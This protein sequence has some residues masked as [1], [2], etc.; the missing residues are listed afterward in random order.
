MEELEYEAQDYCMTVHLF[1]AVSS[2]A[3]ANFVL[4]RTADD[5]KDSYGTEV[6]YTL[7][8]NF[9]VDDVL[10]PATTGDKTIKLAKDVKA[11]CGNEGFNLTKFVGNTDHI[12]VN[13]LNPGVSA[14]H[15]Y[16]VIV[17]V[18]IVMK[19]TVVGSYSRDYL[20]R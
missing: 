16:C 13:G 4:Q 10:E 2:P 17:R 6:A 9:N 20:G 12:I 11:V 5:N 1:G 18:R 14:V 8:R 3:C 15:N 7:R 19:R